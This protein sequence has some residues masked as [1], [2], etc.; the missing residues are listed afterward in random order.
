MSDIGA[1]MLSELRRI[2]ELLEDRSPLGF[3]KKPQPTYVFIKHTPQS[4]WYSRDKQQGENIP[5]IDRD[6]VGYL[7]NVWRFDR[8]DQSTH[9]T[10]P[11]LMLHV[12]ADR[13][14]II[15]SGLSTN[16]SKSLL[17]GLL[18]LP[19]EALQEPLTLLVEDNAGG[20]GRPT[21]FAR[22]EW[23]GSRVKPTFD[24]NASTEALL[25][26]IQAK[27]GLTSPFEAGEHGD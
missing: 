19:L 23:Q 13:E 15:Q 2:R 25:T 16:F 21:V 7:R 20:K 4:L 6:L 8:L 5:I 18:E 27:F 12:H 17:V 1:Q 10:V 3:G 26:L 11:K 14:Y 24:K 22:L 9:E